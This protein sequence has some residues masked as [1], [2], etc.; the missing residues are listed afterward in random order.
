MSEVESWSSER[1][2]VGLSESGPAHQVDAGVGCA[3]GAGLGPFAVAA[4]PES[5]PATD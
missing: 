5:R 3:I 2:P 4:G 1:L